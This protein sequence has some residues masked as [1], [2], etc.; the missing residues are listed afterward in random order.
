MSTITCS[1][2]DF[3]C[4]EN[5]KHCYDFNQAILTS[6]MSTDLS[7]LKNAFAMTEYCDKIT[8]RQLATHKLNSTNAEMPDCV[9][10]RAPLP[11]YKTHCINELRFSQLI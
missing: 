6:L 3:Q 1:I 8:E 4:L 11:N 9:N 7:I 5:A 10:E 2:R